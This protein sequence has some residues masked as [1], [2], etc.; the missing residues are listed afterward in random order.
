[1]I[2][3]ILW[4]F[5]GVLTTSPFE[6]F[7]R[8]EEEHQ[9]PRDFI[10]GIN[11]VN[12]TTNAWSKL[13]NGLI[14]IEAFDREFESE[15]KAA[16]H[17]IPGKD[18]LRLLSGAVRPRMVKALKKC[19]QQFKVGCLTNNIQPDDGSALHK[20][21]EQLAE[22]MDIMGLFDVIIESSVEG[23]RK[24]DPEIY[25]IALSRLAVNAEEC[26]FLDDL[27]INLK[28]ARAMGMQTI[29]VL[30]VDQALGELAQHTGIKF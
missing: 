17:S 21:D 8:Y 16:G 23:V 22:Y 12:P 15:S 14:S 26:I 13:E 9:L 20:N 18:V 11:A 5:G 29:K 10:R 25:R 2:K 4:D 7:N 24:P 19:K 1:M 6:A 27:G 3:A 30:T 28:P